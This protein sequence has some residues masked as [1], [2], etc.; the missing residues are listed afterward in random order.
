MSILLETERR[1]K[2]EIRRLDFVFSPDGLGSAIETHFALY[3]FHIMDA[4]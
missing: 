2:A 1:T 3:L 4:S